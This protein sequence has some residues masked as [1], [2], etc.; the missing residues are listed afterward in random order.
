MFEQPQSAL[1]GRPS[2][3]LLRSLA[4]V[5]NGEFIAATFKTLPE[6]AEP[7]LCSFYGDPQNQNAWTAQPVGPV[8]SQNNNFICVGS[9]YRKDGTLRATSDQAAAAHFILLDDLGGKVP[10]ER[11]N[12]FK[13]SWLTE[14]SPDNYQGG[15]ILSPPLA[16]READEL[17]RAIIDAG[18][19]DPSATGSTTRWARL[20]DGVNG[21]PKHIG[22]DGKPFKCRLV[23]W[24]PDARYTPQQIIDGLCLSLTQKPLSERAKATA[25]SIIADDRKASFG[26]TA[27]H[28]EANAVSATAEGGRNGRLFEAGVK[29][30][31]LVAGGCLDA[32]QAQDTLISAAQSAGLT[33]GEAVATLKSAWKVGAQNPRAPRDKPMA[34]M[35]VITHQPS[36]PSEATEETPWPELRPLNTELPPVDLL[37]PSTMLPDD[38][39]DYLLDRADATQSNIDHL[40]VLAFSAYGAT[41]GK[42]IRVHPR[43]NDSDYVVVP[44][45]WALGVAPPSLGKTPLFNIATAPLRQLEQEAIEEHAAYVE[46]KKRIDA[47]IWM[48]IKG[49]D[50]LAQKKFNQ[51]K[52]DEANTELSKRPPEPAP[53][54]PTPSF[55]ADT[56]TVQALALTLRDNPAG[57]ALFQDEISGWLA[58]VSGQENA[59]DRNF[60]LSAYNGTTS[61]KYD[62]ISRGKLYLPEVCMSIGGFIQPSKLA[63]FVDE[64]VTEK[65][66]DGL[67]QRFQLMVM[68][69]PITGWR[70]VDKPVNARAKEKYFQSFRKAGALRK[71]AEN[72]KLL[73]KLNTK[74]QQ[75]F[76]EW[77]ED[78]N[79]RARGNAVPG[80]FDSHL[81][82]LEKTVASIALMLEIANGGLDN[83]LEN[84]CAEISVKSLQGALAWAKYL[85]SHA[86]RIYGAT[87]L[88]GITKAAATIVERRAQLPITFSAR[89]IYRFVWSRL[90]N[91]RETNDAL[92]LLLAD[93]FIRSIKQNSYDTKGRSLQ[94]Y[95]WHPDIDAFTQ[96][97]VIEAPLW[98]EHEK[99]K[100]GGK[101]RLVL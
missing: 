54:P 84:S 22:S 24:R 46:D 70:C 15:I 7:V 59:Q 14:T 56:T 62:T 16:K 19:S 71:S 20:P 82:K 5:T 78:I 80:A 23:E 37:D 96:S 90:K 98:Q 25:P 68:P 40:A 52:A 47:P 44:N 26:L 49:A 72:G 91:A 12:G 92:D 27:L 97:N 66:N 55:L 51:G 93:G 43:R 67:L 65:L 86:R 33:K 3:Q 77:L 88:V 18:L 94:R 31:S 48:Q 81:I 35:Q 36:S 87:P 89:D 61:Y 4:D 9:F 74:A 34:K 42:N 63:P 17:V 29:C 58:A 45:P 75:L 95:I 76:S 6:N 50:K 69:D 1:G 41:L 30:A 21:K 2:P 73:W 8:S 100:S 53:M 83:P 39:R 64:A 85:E 38:W 99:P 32:R 10:L 79:T 11:L 60:Y 57:V 13:L 101:V 28:D